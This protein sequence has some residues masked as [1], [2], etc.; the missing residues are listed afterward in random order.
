MATFLVTCP[1]CSAGL[2]LAKAPAAGNKLKCPKC[3]EVFA[4]DEDQEEEEQEDKP[5]KRRKK[6]AAQ[7][8]NLVFFLVGGGLV[9]VLLL[10]CSAGGLLWALGVFDKKPKVAQ[11]DTK[12]DSGTDPGGDTNKGSPADSKKGPPVDSK[13]GPVGGNPDDILQGANWQVTTLKDCRCQLEFPASPKLSHQNKNAKG[14]FDSLMYDTALPNGAFFFLHMQL[15]GSFTANEKADHFKAVVGKLDK[16][17]QKVKQ[18]NNITFKGNA[19]LE[20]VFEQTF[21]KGTAKDNYSRYFWIDD[22]LYVLA[23]EADKGLIGS[24]TAKRFFESFQPLN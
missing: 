2:R 11:V 13:K 16:K 10:A 7:G 3:G 15:T 24:G 4:A 6:K 12:K 5:K 21:T 14:Q 17:F 18:Q 22:R 19:C 20:L 8:S 23:C 1:S 9:V